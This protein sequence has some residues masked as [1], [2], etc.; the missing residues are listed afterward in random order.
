MTGK[1]REDKM[2]I[3]LQLMRTVIGATTLLAIANTSNAALT[4]AETAF[5]RK[6]A[7]V[8]LDPNLTG[9]DAR[10]Q[11][12]RVPV[13]LRW[14]VSEM[15]GA[16][17]RATAVSILHKAAGGLPTAGPVVDDAELER[18]RT[19]L[20]AATAEA[21]ERERQTREEEQATAQARELRAR[22]EERAAAEARIREAVRAATQRERDVADERVRRAREEERAAYNEG[23]TAALAAARTAADEAR[24]ALEEAQERLAALEAAARDAEERARVATEALEE[25]GEEHARMARTIAEAR[26]TEESLRAEIRRL[27]APSTAAGEGK[28]PKRRAGALAD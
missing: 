4:D 15:P 26:V 25:K 10:Q 12:S 6:V 11:M 7:G 18:M 2:N 13:E 17:E 14:L 3:K 24:V 28:K 20:A 23:G 22:E 16:G 1:L 21:D 27:R 9:R 19:A 5:A 8:H